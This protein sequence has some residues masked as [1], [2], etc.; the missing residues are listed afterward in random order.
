MEVSLRPATD[1]DSDFAFHVKERAFRPQVEKV[2]G[3]EQVEVR[4]RR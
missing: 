3:W 1:R 4:A 2:W